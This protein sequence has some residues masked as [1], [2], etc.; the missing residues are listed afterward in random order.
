MVLGWYLVGADVYD[1]YETCSLVLDAYV[2]LYDDLYSLFYLY[3][4]LYIT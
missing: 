2:F 1:E 3:V 4:N